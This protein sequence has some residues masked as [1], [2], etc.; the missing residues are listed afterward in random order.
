MKIA[1]IHNSNAF[2]GGEANSSELRRIFQRRGH[3]V[4]YVNTQEANWQRVL[5]LDIARA[6]IVG[7]DGTVEQVAPH[8]REIPFGILPFGTA[9]NIGQ[10]LRQTSDPELLAS[11]LDTAEVSR[12]DLGKV[13]T[14]SES[15]FFLEGSG[16]G[17]F[18]ELI[19][20][21]QEWP[22]KKQMEEAES[23]EEKFSHAIEQLREVGRTYKGTALEL[24]VDGAPICDRFIML[25]VMNMNLAG[26]R[27]NLAPDADPSDGMLDLVFVREK[28]RDHFCRWI[29]S[30]SPGQK[31]AARFESQ[32]CS[33]IEI[34]AST[35]APLHID[36]R[37]IQK[38]VFPLRV[39]LEPAALNHLV[40]KA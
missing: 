4:A 29:E 11:K 26:P 3:D 12:L 14:G 13:M 17:V 7:G 8:L 18:A 37:L 28:N 30:Q 5:S 25:G 9:N 16:L 35:I 20:A 2:R 15:G 10:C 32:R 34:N 27:L 36:S 23:R 22:Q 40:V 24:K 31:T 38:P 39:E 1:L 33:R 19:L 6:I 21:M